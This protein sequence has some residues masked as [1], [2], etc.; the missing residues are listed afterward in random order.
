MGGTSWGGDVMGDRPSYFNNDSCNAT[1]P[2]EQVSYD[3]I[4]GAKAGAGWPDCGGFCA[5]C[6]ELGAN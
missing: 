3:M 2:V 1:R 4:R 6:P 5:T